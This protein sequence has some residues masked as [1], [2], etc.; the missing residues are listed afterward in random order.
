MTPN[1]LRQIRTAEWHAREAIAHAAVGNFDLEFYHVDAG[2]EFV[3]LVTGRKP[4]CQNGDELV[5]E[6]LNLVDMSNVVLLPGA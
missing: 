1:E 2:C 6:C 3:Q 4:R 5:A